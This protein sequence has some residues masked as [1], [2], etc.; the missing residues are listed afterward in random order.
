VEKREFTLIELL[1]VIA[2]IAILAAMLL[3]ALNQAKD[4]AHTT[5]CMNNMKQIGLAM[6]M[7]VQ[8]SDFYLTGRVMWG[9]KIETY[10][11]DL[12]PFACPKWGQGKP[13][14]LGTNAG[15]CQRTYNQYRNERGIRGG[16]G[17]GCY[18][19]GSTNGR[20]I[21]SITKPTS[22][23]WLV[24]TTGGCTYHSNPSAG[25][26]D[27]PRVDPRHSNGINATFVD[28]HVQWERTP[29]TRLWTYEPFRTYLRY[30]Q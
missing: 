5:V 30:S 29:D 18:V 2:I 21:T 11:G 28:G 13:V 25:C 16:Y 24:E 26:A 6:N 22:T 12:K 1:V 15:Y 9:R 7:Y 4:R 27:G 17:V 20:R 14:L 10:V 23:I 3:P 8:D 19:T